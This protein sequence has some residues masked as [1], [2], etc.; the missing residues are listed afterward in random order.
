[1]KISFHVNILLLFSYR[2]REPLLL[3][4]TSKTVLSNRN[5]ITNKRFFACTSELKFVEKEKINNCVQELKRKMIEIIGEK[6]GRKVNETLMKNEKRKP[7]YPANNN[8]QF[9]FGE[10]KLVKLSELN[11]SL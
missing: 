4:T 6:A 2:V 9:L 10:K 8:E 7:D 1:M 3:V 5:G 11:F